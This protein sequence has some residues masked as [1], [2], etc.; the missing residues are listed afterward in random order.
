MVLVKSVNPYTLSGSVDIIG[1]VFKGDWRQGQEIKYVVVTK[2]LYQVSA[3]YS[4]A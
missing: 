1:D 4:Q 3:N 2:R